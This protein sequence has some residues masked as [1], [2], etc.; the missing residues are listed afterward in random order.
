MWELPL[1]GYDNRDARDGQPDQE[2]YL[3]DAFAGEGSGKLVCAS[4]NPTGARPAGV[5]DV[6]VFDA[7]GLPGMLVDRPA[8]WRGEQLAPAIPGWAK[9]QPNRALFP[10]RP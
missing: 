10:S 6:S 8:L 7:G 1:T 4:C 3:Y 2:V 5:L 9:I